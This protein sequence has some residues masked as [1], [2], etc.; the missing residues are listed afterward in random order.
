MSVWNFD[1]LC[2]LFI[3]YY[4]FV[5]ASSWLIVLGKVHLYDWYVFT[6]FFTI[7]YCHFNS[8]C[9]I[10]KLQFDSMFLKILKNNY[11]LI[12]FRD[13]VVLKI[14]LLLAFTACPKGYQV[15]SGA[16]GH[17]NC[18]SCWFLRGTICCLLWHVSLDSPSLFSC[19]TKTE[20]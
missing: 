8:P 7:N 18:L 5:K 9:W 14:S 16:S 3:E 19:T 11:T 4:V 12:F 17:Y 20:T 1:Q 15:S 6:T 13:K 10:T 2:S